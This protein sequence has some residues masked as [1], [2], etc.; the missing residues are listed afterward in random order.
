MLEIFDLMDGK[1][2]HEAKKL[3]REAVDKYSGLSKLL[4][5]Y[6]VDEDRIVTPHKIHKMMVYFRVERNNDINKIGEIGDFA[7]KRIELLK[8][9]EFR[10]KKNCKYLTV[11]MN[12]IKYLLD[13][14]DKLKAEVQHRNQYKIMKNCFV[15]LSPT[16]IKWFVR[17][18]CRK[19][20]FTKAMSEIIKEEKLK[21]VL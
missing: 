5:I 14:Y 9:R 11:N 1:P 8:H 12:N 17:I 18:L 10:W 2:H 6:V 3:L 15:L 20:Q 13:V 19:I 7:A 4:Q 16:D 21:G